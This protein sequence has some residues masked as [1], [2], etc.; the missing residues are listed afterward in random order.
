MKIVS[1]N[2]WAG[3]AGKDKLLAFFE[4]HREIDIFCLQEIWSGPIKEL[5]GMTGGNS[6]EKHSLRMEYGL[7]E[8]SQVLKD[9][10]AYL[11][12]HLFTFGLLMLVKKSIEVLE[13]GEIFAHKERGYIPEGDVGFH[14]RNV[15]YVKIA[16]EKGNRT[17]MNFHGLWNG[18]G[19]GDSEER[20]LQSEKIVKLIKQQENPLVLCGDFNLSPETESIK[21]L[22]KS[23][24]RNL[25]K[26][27]GVTSTR[28]SLYTRQE[29]FA[30]YVFTSEGIDVRTFKVLPDEVSDH[31][32]LYLDFS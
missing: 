15:Q 24:L 11:R 9:H 20:I 27:W 21:M 30:D 26:E 10:R 1:L 7:Q 23:G 25:I 6:L 3:K 2:T 17:I 29:K 12:P 5:K 13:E 19:K 31:S 16:T 14:A 8:I 32:P 18:K 22:E 28:T 4:S